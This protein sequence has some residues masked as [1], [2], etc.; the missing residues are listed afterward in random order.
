MKM[1]KIAVVIGDADQHR[2][3]HHVDQ[4][5]E[6]LAVVHGAHA[7]NEAQTAAAARVGRAGG[8]RDKR[9][10]IALPGGRRRARRESVLRRTL[11]T[12]PAQSALPQFW[13]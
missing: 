9:L 2:E 10:L 12:Q 1:P 6:E 11:R 8:S 3:D 7:G 5:L 13:Q 4:A